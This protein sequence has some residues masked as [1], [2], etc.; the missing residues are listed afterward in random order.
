MNEKLIMKNDKSL[1]YKV[2]KMRQENYIFI[3]EC[4]GYEN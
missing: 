4:K 2:L 3:F 1:L